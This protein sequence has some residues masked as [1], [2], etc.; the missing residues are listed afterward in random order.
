MTAFFDR[1]RFGTDPEN[2]RI[3]HLRKMDVGQRDGYF[4]RR[5]VCLLV[6][7]VRKVLSYVFQGNWSRVS[8]DV[9]E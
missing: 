5:V 2:S 4:V 6:L 1:T 9:V 3:G 8:R 7:S